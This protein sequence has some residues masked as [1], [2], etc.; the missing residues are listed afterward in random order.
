[1]ILRFKA[2]LT[3]FGMS[4]LVACNTG[5]TDPSTSGTSGADAPALDQQ[6]SDGT[7]ATDPGL[8]D[9]A[10]SVG[11]PGADES[12]RPVDGTGSDTPTPKEH[13]EVVDLM[14]LQL[15]VG[16]DLQRL[17]DL[18]LFEVGD[19][20]AQ[21]PLGRINCYVCPE[22]TDETVAD[23]A[24]AADRLSAFVDI[25]ET[26]IDSPAGP[27][28]CEVDA[29]DANLQFIADLD[30]VEVGGLLVVEPESSANCY[31]L[32]CADDILAAEEAT[33]DRARAVAAIA[34][35]AHA[36]LAQVTAPPV[37][38]VPD[39]ALIAA[40]VEAVDAN[41]QTLRELDVV[42]V[43]ALVVDVPDE[44]FNC[45]GAC[46]GWVDE[47]EAATAESAVA[48]V[49]LTALATEVADL[50]P[51]AGTCEPE[52]IDANLAALGA[53]GVVHIGGLI[54]AQPENN[55]MCYN[56]PCQEDI[57]AAETETCRRAG[58]LAHLVE[59]APSAE[60]TWSE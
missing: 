11:D 60:G 15:D 13:P 50:P 3:A 58:V 10:G 39:A 8:V 41:L 52:A 26:A 2:V 5:A 21:T 46:P 36:A 23:W 4:A 24:A 14:E 6:V 51:A 33:C 27:A 19:L 47:I 18:E 17:R 37:N 34:E 40:A 53:L 20:V 43:H 55:P 56:L 28:A 45:Y 30:I 57:E 16:H 31:N 1:M 32:P 38:E 35:D 48:L 12:T 29:V 54:E 49:E 9:G 44:A 42:E 59:G 7:N 22:P 25:A